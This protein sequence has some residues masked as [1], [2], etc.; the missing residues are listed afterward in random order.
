[1][2]G[3]AGA[4]DLKGRRSFPPQ[5]LSAMLAAIAHR[6]P[7]DRLVHLEPGLAL[8]TNRLAIVDLP[9]GRQPLT[10][11]RGDVWVSFNG[12]LFDYPELRAE[13]SARGHQLATECDT[14]LWVHLYEDLG[15][16]VFMRAG[17]QF[18]VALWDR[19]RR[20]LYL[21]RDRVGICPLFYAQQDGWLL[22]ASEIK[23]L[24]ASGLITPRPD[25]K[26]LHHFF[27]SLSPASTRTCFEGVSPLAPGHYLRIRE[28]RLDLRQYWDLDFPDAGGERRFPDP[29]AAVEELEHLLRRAVRRRLRAD[30]PVVSYISGGLDS[31]TVL[32]LSSQELGKP[33]PAFTIGLDRAG[34][35]ERLQAAESAAVLGC[36][37]TTVAMNRADIAAL[38]PRL[39]RAAESPVL[40]TSCAC[41]LRLS[42][43]VH[44]SGYRVVLTGEGADEALAGYIWFRTEQIG[45]RIARWSGQFLP[46]LLHRLVL[47]RIGGGRAHRPPWAAMGGVRTVQQELG[48]WYAQTR[49]LLFS[50]CMWERLGD[51]L[52][53]A[54][55][56][57]TNQ[58]IARWHPLNR[59]LYVGYKTL[60]P[61]MLLSA[62]GDR[63]AMSSSVETR[64]PFLDED[65]IS[66]CAAI[67]PDCK[68]HRMTEKW[69]LRRVADHALPPPIAARPK[70]MFRATLSQTFLGPDRP[71]WVDQLLSR[72]SLLRTG[73]FD[74]E[75]VARARTLV[76]RGSR[77]TP[78]RNFA[79][80][81]ALTAVI[82]TQLWHHTY[83]GGN[84]ADMP[85]WTPPPNPSHSRTTVS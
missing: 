54:E 59:S 4:I 29:R 43:K 35:D 71:A 79:F 31:T 49:E 64:Y 53:F 44:D 55:M 9:H 80:D 75:G 68:L 66:F 27:T 67:D 62:K 57:I 21:A 51:H 60:L 28:D 26:G 63:V 56:G 74:P 45:I 38:Y 46:R 78:A 18:A 10:N 76:A 39:I 3:I 85:T 14:E 61:G 22:W 2:C 30:V 81:L 84:L 37:L 33:L 13:L 70:T 34:P 50:T 77:W 32:A 72:E 83:C 73:Y 5:A 20:T 41:M 16:Q 12:E 52:P 25:A 69:L 8:G 48:E 11:E 82:T 1:M 47:A 65:V 15:E 19:G 7:D 36:P 40:D 23:A 6:G 24:L 58:R 17:G 42:G